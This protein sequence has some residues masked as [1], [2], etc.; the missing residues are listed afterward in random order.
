[1]SRYSPQAWASGSGTWQPKTWHRTPGLNLPPSQP[2]G[3]NPGRVWTHGYEAE[4]YATQMALAM[5]RQD[6]TMGDIFEGCSD[7]TE[8]LAFMSASKI[9]AIWTGVGIGTLLGLGIAGA[10]AYFLKK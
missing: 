3:A 9:D 7:K 1:M 4:Q 5:P 8:M 10:A 2:T 6:E